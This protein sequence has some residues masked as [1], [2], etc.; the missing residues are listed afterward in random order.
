MKALDELLSLVASEQQADGSFLSMSSADASGLVPGTPY[1]TTFVTSQI[2]A[3]LSLLK[4]NDVS[5]ITNRASGFLKS[6]IRDGSVNYWH[7]ECP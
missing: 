7:R 1:H 6:Q 2:M 5:R 3:A 4:E